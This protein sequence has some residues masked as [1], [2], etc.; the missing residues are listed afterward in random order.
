METSKSWQ[1]LDVSFCQETN[2]DYF[3]SFEKKVFVPG[4]SLC[5][6]SCDLKLKITIQNRK[7][8]VNLSFEPIKKPRSLAMA[9]KHFHSQHSVSLQWENTKRKCLFD[10]YLWCFQQRQRKSKIKYIEKAHMRLSLTEHNTHSVR[11]I[12]IN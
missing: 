11:H 7:F 9:L 1:V 12:Q 5:V 8:S 4:K 10:A 3:I 6:N 2:K